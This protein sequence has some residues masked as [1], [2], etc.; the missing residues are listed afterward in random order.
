MGMKLKQD[1][2]Y[3]ADPE[4]VFAMFCD[5]AFVD[6]KYAALGYP[7]FEVLECGPVGDGG[8]IKTR[9]FVTANIPGFAKKLLGDTTEMVQTDTWEGVGADGVRRGTWVIDIP[10]KPMG[11]RGTITLAADGLGSLVRIDGELKA[12]VPL[13]GGKLESFAGG[14]AAKTLKDEHNFAVNWLAEH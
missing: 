13:I 14:E 8:V 2:R 10:G 4:R 1:D 3:D 5:P 7:K 6:A 9:R 11:A 12:S